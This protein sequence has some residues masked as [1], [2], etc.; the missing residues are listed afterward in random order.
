MKDGFFWGEAALQG[1]ALGI[2][3]DFLKEGFSRSA[4]SLTEAALGPLAMIP[5]TAQRLT[6]GARR[7][8]ENGEHV[9]F[10]SA[11][12]DDIGRFTP[13]SNLWYA[14]LLFNRAIVDNLHRAIDPDYAGSFRRASERARKTYGQGFWWAP[15]ES[16][17]TRAPDLGVVR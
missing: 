5:A 8:A 1:G 7:M 3:G 17:P 16:A 9:N 15:G 13:G 2:Y 10:G 14:R 12:A 4:T 11:L 6:S